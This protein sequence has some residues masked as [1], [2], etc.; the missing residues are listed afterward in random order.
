MVARTMEAVETEM[1]RPGA[2]VASPFGVGRSV[3]GVFGY[4]PMGNR[5]HLRN[6]A[7][8]SSDANIT[9]LPGL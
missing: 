8:N 7:E 4:G 2:T 1:M 9:P 5:C 3:D 6:L